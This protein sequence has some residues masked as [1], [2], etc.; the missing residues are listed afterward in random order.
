MQPVGFALV[1][2]VDG[3]AHLTE[4][5]VHPLHGRKGLGSLL[6]ARV[7]DW[8]RSQRFRAVTL[9]TFSHVPWNA[10]FYQRAGFRVLAPAEVGPKLAEILAEEASRGLRQRVAMSLDLEA[11]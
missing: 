1:Q 6:L 8:A 11:V 5:D 7:V 9:T 4:M 2:L 3:N 10:P